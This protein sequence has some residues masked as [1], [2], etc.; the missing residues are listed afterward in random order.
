[1]KPAYPFVLIVG[2]TATGKSHLALQ[3][4]EETCGCILNMDSLQVYRRLDIGTAKPSKADQSRVPHFLFDVV[5][6][7]ATLTAGDYRR[8][9]L[10]VL[11]AEI[12]KGPVFGVGGSGFYVQ[13]LEKGMFNVDKPRPEVEARLREQVA[14]HG[15][16]W[17]Y[18]ELQRVDPESAAR[19]HPHDTYRVTRALVIV[20]D[21]GRKLSELRS[22]FQAQPLPYAMV[23]MG[24]SCPRETL[25]SRV[26][27]RV[28]AM[29]AAGW[30]DEVELLVREGW[31]DWA[32][33]QSVGY[34]ECLQFLNG[35]L[36]KEQLKSR[37]VE[38]TM[39][40]AKRQRTWFQ[41]DAEIN[42]LNPES[43]EIEA[44]ARL[45]QLGALA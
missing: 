2:A 43:A 41:R 40:L 20:R 32:P 5:D 35:E 3:L 44:R 22:D 11:A 33:L 27:A 15:P 21:S 42:W 39:Q 14:Q 28:D 4:A 1:V 25:L 26:A 6:P 9:A 31:S 45:T 8:L 13:A 38:K 7:G 34:R 10:D 18:E 24:M 17:A 36:P 19:L 37:I 30:L 23:K 16:Q 29:L 12:P